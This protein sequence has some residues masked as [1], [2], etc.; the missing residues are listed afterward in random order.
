MSA[1]A[2]ILP[3]IRGSDPGLSLYHRLSPDGLANPYPLYHLLRTEDPVHWDPYLHAW[4]VTS[5][6]GVVT[7]LQRFSATRIPAPEQLT[8]LGLSE[9]NPI[10]ELLVRQMIFM[11]PPCHTR[12]RALA[13]A[14]FMPKRVEA[15]QPHIQ[16]ITDSLINAVLPQGRMDVIAGLADLLPATVTAELMGVPVA[17]RDQ[18][19]IW[20]KDFSEVLG[21]F[22]HNPGGTAL[23]LKTVEDMTAYFRDRMRE[24]ERHPRD[25]VLHTL[26][27]AEMDGDRLTE[28]E[29]IANCIIT[30]TGGQETTTSLIGNGLLLLLRNPDELARLQADPSLLPAAIDEFLRYESPIQHT[31]RLAPADLELGGKKIHKGEAVIAVIGAAN[32]D[33]ARFPDPDRLD[34]G[35]PDNRNLAFGWGAHFCFGAPLARIEARIAFSTIFQ[36]LRNLTLQAVPL[37]WH[38]NIGFRGL[39]ALPVTFDPATFEPV[40]PAG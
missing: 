26:M 18:L 24:Q 23:M 37:A 30:M 28:E 19:K 21:S 27:T 6:E 9:L 38:R 13:A 5:Y 34:I 16:E 39:E 3:G 22:Q 12:V 11:D 15:L 8:A 35:R 33:P 14:A 25:G 32:R 10:A 20:S 7:V 4:V 31:A 17:D 2:R 29:V 36:R 1:D 40:A